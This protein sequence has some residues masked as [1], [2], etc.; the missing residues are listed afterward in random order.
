MHPTTPNFIKPLLLQP[1]VA[2][3]LVLAL[4]LIGSGLF[5]SSLASIA[6]GALAL[7][8]AF[9]MQRKARSDLSQKPSPFV[10]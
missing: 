2:P 4:L 6:E 1:L 5:E 7:L 3:L 9:A 10:C 8:A